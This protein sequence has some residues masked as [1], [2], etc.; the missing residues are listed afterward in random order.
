MDTSGPALVSALSGAPALVKP[1]LSELGEIGHDDDDPVE[2]ARRL[3][4]TSGAAVVV[5][6]GAAGMVLVPRATRGGPPSRWPCGA[7][8][9]ERVTQPSRRSPG[10][11]APVRVWPTILVD[12]VAVSGAAVLAP[13]AGE[14]ALEDHDRLASSV[15]VEKVGPA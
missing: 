3:A 8:R 6:L 9:P 5:S 15:V 2:A 7:T 14:F 4:R 10:G 1:N 12:A 11:S 13:Y